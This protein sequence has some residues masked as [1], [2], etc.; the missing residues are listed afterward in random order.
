MSRSPSSLGPGQ[1]RVWRE[2]KRRRDSGGS[3]SGRQLISEVGPQVAERRY[4]R[5]KSCG[6]GEQC[7]PLPIPCHHQLGF[8]HSSPKLQ[9]SSF[10]Q[11]CCGLNF[12]AWLTPSPPLRNLG[13]ASCSCA[14]PQSL[15]SPSC[16]QP[17]PLSPLPL[18]PLRR[19]V[20]AAPCLHL[21]PFSGTR[22]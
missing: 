1:W 19:L 11:T 21:L 20:T 6:A 4:N 14:T 15:V 8:G 10:C 18:S 9:L 17:T 12:W 13:S 3:F 5:H 22:F 16:A 7:H 2:T